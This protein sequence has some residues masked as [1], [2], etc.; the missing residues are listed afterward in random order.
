MREWEVIQ[1]VE[2]SCEWGEVQWVEH[3]FYVGVRV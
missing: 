1:R 2:Y 3:S